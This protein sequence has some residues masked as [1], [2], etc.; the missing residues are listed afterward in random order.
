[1]G[2]ISIFAF[3]IFVWP[4]PR[5]ISVRKSVRRNVCG[6]N[7]KNVAQALWDYQRDKGTFPPA[8]TVD[9]QGRRLH[10]WRTLILPYLGEQQLYQ[11]IDLT[12]PWDDPANA[13]AA[14]TSLPAFLCPSSR[15]DKLY[16]TY[17]AVVGPEF[18]FTG[19]VA[20]DSKEFTDGISKT[21]LIV[22]ANEKRAVHWMSPNDADENLIRDLSDNPDLELQHEYCIL[23]VFADGH[24]DILTTD[25]LKESLLAAFTIAGG[26]PSKFD[27]R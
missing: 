11:S 9:Q 20:R 12:K 3:A 5:N 17:L 14:A 23:A 24:T 6:K 19:S 15:H 16:T 10:S 21:I 27:N 1:M 22:D 2:L 18:A 4:I 7:L 25:D 13:D 26:D 8:Y